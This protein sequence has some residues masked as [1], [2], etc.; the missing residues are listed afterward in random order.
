MAF[1]FIIGSKLYND[2][3]PAI[4]RQQAYGRI[5]I[6]ALTFQ[7]EKNN[8]FT[9]TDKIEEADAVFYADYGVKLQEMQ[10]FTDY[11]LL[12]SFDATIKDMTGEILWAQHFQLLNP[13]SSIPVSMPLPLYAQDGPRLYHALGV[14]LLELS[15]EA[16]TSLGGT[17]YNP[18][19]PVWE[20]HKK[21]PVSD[22][23]TPSIVSTPS[24]DSTPESPPSTKSEFGYSGSVNLGNYHALVIGNNNYQYLENLRTA[25]DDALS[26][27]AI[28]EKKYGFKVTVLKDATREGIIDSLY[29][30][31]KTLSE[32]DNLLIYYAGHGFLDK[33]ANLGYWL[34]VEAKKDSDSHWVSNF[35][36]TN[37]L[38]VIAAKHIMIVA[39]SCYS[40][41]FTRDARGLVVRRKNLDDDSYLV[42][43]AKIKS[44]V[45]LSSGGIEPVE[46][47]EGLHSV[48]NK[49]FIQALEENTGVIDSASIYPQIKRMVMMNASQTPEYGDIRFTGSEGGDFLFVRQN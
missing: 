38:K 23:F 40:G 3:I 30:Y 42:K 15:K 14:S 7:L 46:D 39:D 5:L 37:K 27:G 45:V 8:L 12:T 33:E 9:V 11:K 10:N 18:Q 31:R 20:L 21:V 24:I 19:F 44:R 1:R 28:L 35:D 32:N 36:I 43:M 34:P 2:I 25:L 48:F 26:V 4:Q 41:S 16:I 29:N 22:D 47:G 6:E 17:P 13:Y 49:Y